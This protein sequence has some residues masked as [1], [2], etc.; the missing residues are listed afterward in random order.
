VP[1]RLG[2]LADNQNQPFRYSAMLAA[3]M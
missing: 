1:A 2:A 3:L